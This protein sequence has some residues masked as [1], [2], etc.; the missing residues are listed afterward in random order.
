MEVDWN[1]IAG[2]L[3]TAA[4]K[5]LIPV[6]IVL[7]IK[8]SAQIWKTIKEKD[9]SLA[10]YLTLAA[11]IGYAAAEEYFHNNKNPTESKMEI[12]IEAAN[13]VLT[14]LGISLPEDV[15]HDAIVGFGVNEKQ[16]SW[17]HPNFSLVFG[18]DPD[19]T[20]RLKLQE[21]EPEE[22][23]HGTDPSSDFGVGD[24][25]DDRDA[26]HQQDRQWADRSD[27]TAAEDKDGIGF[28]FVDEDRTYGESDRA[29]GSETA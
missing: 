9:P 25:D 1:A 22:A 6:L 16:F 17:T 4:M 14:S 5:I 20:A 28:S 21:E 26:G 2:E 3:V 12:A 19:G 23:C 13:E 7:V 24:R 11:Q 8:W 27:Q 15:L 10:K 29:D 18:G